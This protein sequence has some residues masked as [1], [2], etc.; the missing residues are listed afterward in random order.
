MNDRETTGISAPPAAHNGQAPLTTPPA[1]QTLTDISRTLAST[2]VMQALMG[3]ED[4][5]RGN[6][7]AIH[8][9]FG[10]HFRYCE[11]LG[12]LSYTGTHWE[13]ESAAL[14][15]QQAAT[16]VLHA[17]YKRARQHDNSEIA[18]CAKPQARTIKNA[19]ELFRPLVQ[20]RVENFDA[21]PDH[22]NVANGVLDLRT[23]VLEPHTPSQRFTYCLP[24]PYNPA[25]DTTDWQTFLAEV[26]GGGD[27]VLS[28]LQQAVGYS[29]TGHTNEEKLFYVYGDPRAGKGVFTETLLTL[30]GRP[31]ST[32][33]SFRT[34]TSDRKNDSNNHDLAPLK[35]ARLI[36]A[37]ESSKRD[38]LNAERVKV[39]TGGNDIYCCY[40]YLTHFSYRPT[41][42]IWLVSNND[43]DADPHDTAVWGRIIRFA[44]P[45][46]W[47]GHE[48]KTLKERLK[49][50]ENLQGVL[51]WAVAGARQW[52]A[53]G[54]LQVPTVLQTAL[55]TVRA[56]LDT[57]QEWLD[58]CTVQT[59]GAFEAH[60]MLYEH[61]RDWCK[62]NGQ[63][64][65]GGSEFG[66]VLSRKGYDAERR[67]LPN[68][69]RDR[70]R[71]GLRLF[72]A[73]SV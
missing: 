11:A 65:C 50:P 5:D 60:R 38:R 49:R 51:A 54:G 24:I 56:E 27:E 69:Q 71:I 29:L 32:E 47:L 40:K 66:R 37:S 64:P 43:V 55:D 6:A 20:T 28:I 1:A 46:S 41:F 44:F 9:V 35:P 67:Y 10:T 53:S 8:S 23:G 34:F 3:Y 16:D 26:V 25:A 58:L 39:L 42:K 31:L 7:Q 48:D 12:W 19:I 33:V 45:H 2:R 21:S 22:L 15:V 14:E 18:Q 52:Y 13:R 72:Y 17:R 36:V 68:G 73:N 63:T 70:C 62:D 57:V 61:Y 30:L 59:D 4:H